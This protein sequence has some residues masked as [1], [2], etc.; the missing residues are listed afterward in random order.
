MTARTLGGKGCSLFREVLV[1][2]LLGYHIDIREWIQGLADRRHLW[3]LIS[4]EE[5]KLL[6]MLVAVHLRPRLIVLPLGRVIE[7]IC[8]FSR[9][10]NP[11]AR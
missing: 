11:L 4:I 9:T 6:L 1:D 5:V 10:S 3:D 2:E 8:A 7:V